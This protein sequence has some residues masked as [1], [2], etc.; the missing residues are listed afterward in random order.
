[1]GPY[2]LG[3]GVGCKGHEAKDTD[4]LMLCMGGLHMGALRTVLVW[5]GKTHIEEV[6][7]RRWVLG[8]ILSLSAS[9]NACCFPARPSL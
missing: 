3:L 7:H 2:R 6:G 9:C 4:R 5:G 1:M 8:V